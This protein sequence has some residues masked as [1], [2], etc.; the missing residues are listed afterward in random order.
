MGKRTRIQREI[1]VIDDLLDSESETVIMPLEIFEKFVSDYSHFLHCVVFSE[2]KCA[3]E[4]A[5][6]LCKKCFKRFGKIILKGINQRLSQKLRRDRE[7]KSFANKI[8]ALNKGKEE[9]CSAGLEKLT[10][11]KITQFR[12]ISENLKTIELIH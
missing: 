1:E 7:L 6:E 11:K 10:G 4:R 2:N 3:D 12:V 8:K 9:L 5:N